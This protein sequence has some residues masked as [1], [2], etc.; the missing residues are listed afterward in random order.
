MDKVLVKRIHILEAYTI[1]YK[2]L[3]KIIDIIIKNGSKY[4]K[5]TW[6]SRYF[7]P[8]VLINANIIASIKWR[9]V[10]SMKFAS[11]NQC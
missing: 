4:A 3:D 7:Y 1:V 6:T 10:T 8:R 2:N 11:F 5:L 9:E